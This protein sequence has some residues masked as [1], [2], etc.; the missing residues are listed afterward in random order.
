MTGP[1]AEPRRVLI[2]GGC[3]FVGSHLAEALIAEGD[4]VSVIDDLSTGSLDNVAHL[5]DHPRFHCT[6]ETIL[7]ETVLSRRVSDSD[8]VFHLAAAVG[9][10]LI[11]R[12]PVHVIETNILGTS[13]VLKA[14]ARVGVPVLLASTSEIYGKSE[15]VP[16]REDSDRLLGPTTRWRWSYSTSKAVDE[17]LGLAYH[18][19]L[20]LP[21]TVFRLFNTVG[22]RQ[23]GHYGMVIPRFVERAMAGE[24]LTVYGD[25]SQTRTFCDVR[26]VVRALAGLMRNPAAVGG[27]FNVGSEHEISILELA[28][29]VLR[30][31]DDVEG[32]HRATA[33]WSDRIRTLSYDDAYERGFEDMWRRVPDLARIRELLGWQPTIPLEVTLRDIIRGR[34]G[35]S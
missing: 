3:G 30:V 19:Q 27:V 32:S 16:F 23:S 22:P 8:V 21:V 26:D 10:E 33:D 17:Y 29:T 34:R 12:D 18:R 11:I 13:A 14:A 31:V 15:A 25:G 2:T 28:R 6:V 4:S 35:A 24:P 1:V 7:D 20:G 9:V 5:A